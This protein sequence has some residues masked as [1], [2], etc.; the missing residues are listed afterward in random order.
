[1][2]AQCSSTQHLRYG[3]LIFIRYADTL[4]L[5]EKQMLYVR[6]TRHPNLR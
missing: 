1:M 2:T 3:Y 6:L 4:R 5:S